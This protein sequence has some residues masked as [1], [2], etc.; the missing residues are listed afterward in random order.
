MKLV[1]ELREITLEARKKCEET[2]EY[3]NWRKKNITSE[4]YAK[5]VAAAKAGLN[6]LKLDQE[7]FSDDQQYWEYYAKTHDFDYSNRKIWWTVQ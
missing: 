6:F 2:P 5:L 3:L 7:H 4:F 1:E